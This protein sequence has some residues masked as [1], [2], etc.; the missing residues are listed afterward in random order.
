M[1]MRRLEATYAS[2]NL[3]R[4]A[5]VVPLHEQI[6][7]DLRTALL[8]LLGAV[9]LVLLIACANVANLLLAR[10]SAREKEIAIRKAL[11]AERGR[12][13]RQ[14]LTE[15][16]AL[17]AIAAGLG[18]LLAGWGV[19]LLRA[20]GPQ[21]IP[22]LDQVAIDGRVLGFTLALMLVTWA[23]FSLAP[24]VKASEPGMH[25]SLKQGGALAGLGRQ[26]MRQ[27][28]AL[29]EVALAVVLLIGAGLL[30]RSFW[31]L[32]RVD[33]GYDPHN[34]LVLHLNLPA[35]RY[36][37]PKS[38]PYLQWPQ[39]TGFQSQLLEKI[40]S[41]PGVESAA[42]AFHSPVE[43]GWTTRMVIAGRP[44]PPPG[45]QDEAHFRPVSEDYFQTIRLALR[46]GRSFTLQDDERHPK[47]V[48]INDAF[49]RR[50]F[51]TENPLGQS[52]NIYGVP[53]EIVGVAGNEKF[54]GLNRESPPAM[55]LPFRQ[56][57]LNGL[58]V[59]VRAAPG[60]RP[61]PMRLALS[62]QKQIWTLDANLAAFDVMSLEDA[63]S[64]ALTQRRFIMSLL[65]TFG[66]LAL[67]LAA[68]GIYGVIDYSVRQR[69]REIGIRMALGAQREQVLK[70]V[71]SQGVKLSLGGAVAG[72]A[73][74]LGLTRFLASQLF[75]VSATDPAT[76]LGAPLLSVLVA[77]LAC[78]IPARRAT[79]VDPVVALRQE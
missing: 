9:G 30:M 7:G 14:L 54:L 62:A 58:A 2:D 39:V 16:M 72:A 35:S 15:N 66:A 18:L 68:V 45:E 34:V 46:R 67:I 70:S 77:A 69:T 60:E 47:V 36:P 48:I 25:D 38:W 23:L 3:G 37:A 21:D 49:A 31:R 76:F 32:L 33:P 50:Y 52:I 74:A 42:V 41:Q 22:R 55:Y 51:P 12:L 61:D 40:K 43:G 4:G 6:V 79:R 24:A 8:L 75:G 56:N 29:S 71:I 64:S 57:P 20:A 53:R 63:L 26:R 17:A 28:L 59:I 44:V 11:G 65:V 73:T 19:D 10:A 1:I 27:Y 78:Y 5:V 13:I